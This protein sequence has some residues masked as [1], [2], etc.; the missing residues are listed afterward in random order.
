MTPQG[1]F[2]KG[3]EGKQKHCQEKKSCSKSRVDLSHCKDSIQNV[4]K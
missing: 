2:T 4:M 1:Q 3:D